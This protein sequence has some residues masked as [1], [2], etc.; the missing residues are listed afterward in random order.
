MASLCTRVSAFAQA[1]PARIAM[2]DGERQIGFGQFWSRA[3]DFADRLRDA[4]L[5]PGQRVALILPNRIEA[6][7]ACYGTWLAGGIVVPLNFQA[8]VRDLVPWLAHCGAAH[9]VCESGHADA[10]QAIQAHVPS[11]GTTIVLPDAPLQACSSRRI[12]AITAPLMDADDVGMILYTSGTT[13]D[14]KGVALT[15]GGMLA[16]ATAVAAYLGLGQGDKVLSVLPFYY[17]YGA[18]VLH[19]HL[20][21]GA[22]VALSPSLLFPNEVV[23][24][25]VGERATGFSGVPSTFALLLAHAC[26][27]GLDLS[28]LRYVSQAGGAMSAALTRRLAAAVPGARVFVMYGQTEATSRIS[29]LPP[30][31]LEEKPGSVG[32][33]VEGLQLRIQREDGS[34]S[35]PGELG[36]VQ[37]RGPSVMRGYWCDDKATAR[38]MQD[39]WLRTGDLGHL[40]AEGFLFLS[41][42]RSDMIKTGAH[43]VFPGDVEEAIAEFPGIREVA[44]VGI[45]DEVMGQVIKAYVIADHLPHRASDRIKAHCRARLAPYKIPRHISFVDTL[46]RTASGKVWRAQLME[47]ETTQ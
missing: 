19:T 15:H 34:A 45:P 42:R 33:P 13:G 9:V 20:I 1:T 7:V 31:K 16:N 36:E 26:W 27:D 10:E 44:V 4:G 14:P 8:R 5:Q 35:G 30:E 39:G 41:G 12:V 21:S 40:D 47:M 2:V 32:I 18:S 23:R 29:W 37:V 17:A 22:C 11:A 46:P 25:L 38:T 43:R 24:A 6:A 3:C 28:N